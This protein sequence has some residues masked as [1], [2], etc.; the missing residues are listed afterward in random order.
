[1]EQIIYNIRYCTGCSACSQV[2]PRGAVAM[3]ADDEGFIFPKIN[4]ERCNDCGLCRRTCPV[5]AAFEKTGSIVTDTDGTSVFT[6]GR[7]SVPV[8]GSRENSAAESVRDE[9]DGGCRKS[10]DGS[11]SNF[12]GMRAF[13]C[14]SKNDG[15][16]EKS[17]SGGIFSEL[18][19]KTLEDGGAVFGAAFD[20]EFNVK[21]KCIESIGELDDLRRSKY[22]QSEIGET[23]KEAEKYLKEGR[24]VLFCGTPC[25]IAGLKAYLGKKYAGLTACDLACFGVPS[26]KVW[27][28]FVDYLE[29]R[30]N[31]RISSVSFRDKSGGWRESSVSIGFE[32]G[33]RYVVSVKKELYLMGFF[34]NLYTRRSC[35]DCRFRIQ[36]SQAD[37]T[38]ADFWGIEKLTG[39]AKRKGPAATDGGT[40]LMDSDRTVKGDDIATIDGDTLP[41]A[42]DTRAR[43]DDT[44][45]RDDNRGISLVITHTKAGEEALFG[46]SDRADIVEYAPEDAVRY[47]PR[48]VSSLPEP[49]GRARFFADMKNGHSFDR[50]RRK[51]MDNTSI[52][53][54]VKCIIKKVL[55]RG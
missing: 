22:V 27:R 21:H 15:T 1:M 32:N 37:I 38:L 36:N 47:N 45:V 24:K 31:S 6:A 4:G 42:G 19:A 40:M 17:S 29:K 10:T 11:A 41:E 16:R 44:A 8:F 25:Q 54:Q 34:K 53:Y 5:N 7:S 18:A 51:Y 52:K 48:L 46:I 9:T 2:C 20:S 50:L 3:E 33:G 35:F 28:M 26:P 30:Y 49:A 14:C 13:A 12:G 39:L 43:E 55:G 23:F